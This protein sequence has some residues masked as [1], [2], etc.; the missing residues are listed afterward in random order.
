VILADLRAL[1]AGAP[2]RAAYETSKRTDLHRFV[3]PRRPIPDPG[4]LVVPGL[5]AGPVP[6][7]AAGRASDLAADALAGHATL[8]GVRRSIGTPTEWHRAPDTGRDWP[9]IPWWRIDIRTADTP[10]EIKVIWELGR[11]RHLVLLARAAH[12]GHQAARDRLDDELVRWFDQN[13]P[14]QG[15]HWYSN[16]ELSLRVLAWLEIVALVPDLAS[17]IR[18]EISGTISLIGR[19]LLADL[20]YTVSTMRNNH[21]LGDALGLIAVGRALPTDGSSR[22]C[23]AIGRRLFAHHLPRQLHSDGSMVED[24]I[25]YHRF[26]LEMLIFRQLVDPDEATRAAM[27]T[28]ARYQ[29]RLGVL[30]GPVPQFGDWDE[31]RVLATGQNPGDLRGTV[32]LALALAGN[33]ARDQWRDEHDECAW[34]APAGQPAAPDESVTDGGDA[35][36]G[37]ARAEVGGLTVWLKA[38]SGPSHG[39][40]DLSS[41]ALR[42][43]SQW[44]L[45]DPGTGTYNGPLEQ[46]N[47]FRSSVAHNVVRVDGQ[48]QLVPHRSFRWANTATGRVGPAMHLMSGGAVL[49]CAHDAYARIGSRV[50]RVVV[51]GEDSIHVTDWVEPPGA[52][53][54]LLS[55]VLPPDVTFDPPTTVKAGSENWHLELPAEPT[56]HRGESEPFDGWWS[57]TLESRCPTTRLEVAATGDTPTWSILRVGAE[58]TAPVDLELRWT[59]SGAVLTVAEGDESTRLLIH[60]LPG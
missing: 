59:S 19:H 54:S 28:A 32:R 58:P 38:G 50:A 5:P 35:G 48:D 25:S 6:T 57:D 10:G 29:C 39:H 34:Y 8:F 3:F 24:S 53:P 20:A 51:I 21:L 40:A 22:R 27:A 13:P 1:G 17:T 55:V 44:L 60:D 56:V 37:V 9:V 31:G 7:A 30:D 26:V 47:W 41:V 49:W 46:R 36:G 12:V 23:L 42:S 52:G 4:P 33:G 43:E 16:L 11:Q 15:I 18:A 2:L 45:G 14:E